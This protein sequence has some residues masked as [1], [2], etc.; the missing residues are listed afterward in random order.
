MPAPHLTGNLLDECDVAEFAA[1]VVIAA[2]ARGHFEMGSEFVVEIAVAFAEEHDLL[3]A[4]SGS[5]IDTGDAQGG[6]KAGERRG[7]QQ[8]Q[9]G[10][11]KRERID[12]PD[13]E[14]KTRH[15]G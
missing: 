7:Q 8:R 6:E 5:G 12:W 13:A 1:R 14:K 3:A 9:R 2:I 4:E 15:G 11:R 10:D